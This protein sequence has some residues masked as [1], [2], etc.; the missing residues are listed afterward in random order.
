MNDTD[1]M[2]FG[3]YK[4][5]QLQCVPDNWLLWFWR[6]NKSDFCL[7]GGF[8]LSEDQIKLMKYIEESFDAKEL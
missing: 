4:G 3:K 7:N 5:E 6:E 1:L 2:L 8:G